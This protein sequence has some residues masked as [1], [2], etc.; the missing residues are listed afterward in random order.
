MNVKLALRINK[1]VHELCKD[2][3]HDI[4]LRI[5]LMVEEE[6]AGELKPSIVLEEQQH[7][8]IYCGLGEVITNNYCNCCGAKQEKE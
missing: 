3:P 5:M 1:M 7:R 4:G 2:V 6:Q 8:C